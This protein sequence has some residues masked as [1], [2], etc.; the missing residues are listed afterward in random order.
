MR[1]RLSRLHIAA[2][3]RPLILPLRLSEIVLGNRKLVKRSEK[4]GKLRLG[5]H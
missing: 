1:G 4:M 5:L 2:V 3:R